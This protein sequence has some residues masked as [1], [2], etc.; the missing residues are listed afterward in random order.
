MSIDLPP[1]VRD[2][3][4]ANAC[5]DVDGML[6]PF[7]D[8]AVITDVGR[9][10]EGRAEIRRLFDAE[11][12]PVKAIFTSEQVREEGGAVVADGHARGDFPGSPLHFTYR[13]TLAADK[14]VALEILL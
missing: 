6:R 14:I 3:V 4:A 13:F 1:P 12:I 2:F 8:D 9:R 5:L 11:V 7:A 10:H